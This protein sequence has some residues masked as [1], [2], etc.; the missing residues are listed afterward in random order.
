MWKLSY[1]AWHNNSLRV[2]NPTQGGTL[3]INGTFDG[4]FQK[5]H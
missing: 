1:M 4:T 5:Q 2:K 3:K